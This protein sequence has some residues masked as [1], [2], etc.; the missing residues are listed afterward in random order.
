[1]IVEPKPQRNANLVVQILL[2]RQGFLGILSGA[3][4]QRTIGY[5]LSRKVMMNVES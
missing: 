4:R 1:V 2:P 5:L 3:W